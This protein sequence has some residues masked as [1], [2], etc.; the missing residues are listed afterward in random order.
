MRWLLVTIVLAACGKSD[1]GPSCGQVTDHMLE[2]TKQQLVGHEG[3][4]LGQRDA[5]I[6][7]CE[8]RDMPAETRR[9]LFA[10]KDIP[11]IAECR[12]GKAEH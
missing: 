12:A 11:A 4:V 3:M 2:V 5:M 10:A 8:Q 7:Q 6:K 1:P 9:C